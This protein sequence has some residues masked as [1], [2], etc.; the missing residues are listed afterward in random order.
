MFNAS[1]I[2]LSS[3]I[4]PSRIQYLNLYYKQE[5]VQCDLFVRYNLFLVNVVCLIFFTGAGVDPDDVQ[6]IISI[7]DEKGFA[8]I[9]GLV[10]VNSA[11]NSTS[12]M[13]RA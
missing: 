2:S 8:T 1:I 10:E 13:R 12:L 11:G 3:K 5:V 4:L 7:Y 6:D 9:T